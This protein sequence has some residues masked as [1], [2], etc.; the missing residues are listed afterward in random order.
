MT[1]THRAND[2]ASGD[3]RSDVTLS[4]EG[5]RRREAILTMA[6]GAL[7]TRVRRRRLRRAVAATGGVA[8]V[9]ASAV[10]LRAGGNDERPQP[11][12]R[13]GEPPRIVQE[14]SAPAAAA[15]TT[16]AVLADLRLPYSF[17]VIDDEEFARELES[18]GAGLIQI[19]SAPP[20]L[21]AA[22]GSPFSLSGTREPRNRPG[23][24]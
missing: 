6:E 11:A 14:V 16:R 15:T 20:R 18:V 1:I 21:V 8:V 4:P 10:L 23:P 17:E 19:G 13:S 9:V 7:R 3:F 2:D 12:E 5:Q 24:G 22:D